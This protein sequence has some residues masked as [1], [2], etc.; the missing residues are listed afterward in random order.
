MAK[1]EVEVRVTQILGKKIT[2]YADDEAE[3]EEK[4]VD[5]VLAWSGV[6]DC[7][8]IEAEEI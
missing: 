3:A 6:E 7:E 8:A 1:Y 5:C 4:A 2:V